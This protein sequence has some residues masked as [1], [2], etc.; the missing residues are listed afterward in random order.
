M[1]VELA[2]SEVGLDANFIEFGY[3]EE[4]LDYFNALIKDSPQSASMQI[5]ELIFLDINMPRMD[6]FEFLEK[7]S[8]LRNVPSFQNII[9]VMNTTSERDSERK[10]AFKYPF[11]DSF[12]TKPL[13]DADIGRILGENF[14]EDYDNLFSGQ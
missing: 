4:A 9:V 5:P 14:V 11:V 8:L 12:V 7:F 6:G 3:A 10:T 13:S 2:F 1:M